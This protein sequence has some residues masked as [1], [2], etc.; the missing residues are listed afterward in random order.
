M[1]KSDNEIIKEIQRGI[2]ISENFCEIS[3]RHSAIFFKM[4]SKYISKK[5][6]EKRLDFFTDKDY[7]I[8]QAVLDFNETKGTKFSTYLAN[9]IKWKCINDYHKDQKSREVKYPLEFMLNCPDKSESIN[10]D[11]LKEVVEMLKKDK[12]PRIHKIFAFRYLEGKNNGVM[13]W[14]EV[15]CQENI[16][17]SVQ[18]CINVHNN[19]LK[20]IRKD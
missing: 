5:F 10:K 4:A 15:C 7:Y 12:D 16:N 14:K 19:Y 6:K 18:G 20:K 13:P 1:Q 8:Y 17:L 2:D 11:K 9:R 3:E